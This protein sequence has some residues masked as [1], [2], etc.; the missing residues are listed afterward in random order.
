MGYLKVANIVRSTV[1]QRLDMINVVFVPKF[2]EAYGALIM[3]FLQKLSHLTSGVYA[4]NI[5]LPRSPLIVPGNMF[6]RIA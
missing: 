2:F 6:K 3:L 4:A 5:S 1:S